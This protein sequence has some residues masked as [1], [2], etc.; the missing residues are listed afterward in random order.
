MTVIIIIIITTNLE[1]RLCNGTV[2]TVTE[3]HITEGGWGSLPV[4]SL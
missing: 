4:R 1:K 3:A 2:I